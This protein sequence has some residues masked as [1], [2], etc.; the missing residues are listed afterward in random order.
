VLCLQVNP[1]EADHMKAIA[2]LSCFLAI[3]CSG[4]SNTSTAN[5][6]GADSLAVT[7]TQPV[8]YS[9]HPMKKVSVVDRSRPDSTISNT[10]IEFA[11][12]G[13]RSILMEP[14]IPSVLYPGQ[15]MYASL[16]FRVSTSSPGLSGTRNNIALW[17]VADWDP[18]TVTHNSLPEGN[19]ASYIQLNEINGEDLAIDA[20]GLIADS[21][22]PHWLRIGGRLM[23]TAE[24]IRSRG[25][26]GALS[27]ASLPL[28]PN[29]IFLTLGCTAAPYTQ[30]I[31]GSCDI[32]G[33]NSPC[34]PGS[35]LCT[36]VRYRDCSSLAARNAY[37]DRCEPVRQQDH[38]YP[39]TC[40]CA[41]G[42]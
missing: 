19:V 2:L 39:S 32:A 13:N 24:S 26:N 9:R 10:M 21:Y 5:N 29:Q 38:P 7:A 3:T 36:L 4:E 42:N 20:K 25:T 17:Q 18:N 23:I 41:P 30:E 35:S 11:L 28:D 31:L 37:M 12:D 8:A 27:N 14:D 6:Y 16:G 22:D 40:Y 33:Y 15:L 1:P 34:P